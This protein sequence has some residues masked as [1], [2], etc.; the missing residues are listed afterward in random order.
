MDKEQHVNKTLRRINKDGK[1]PVVVIYKPGIVR[2]GFLV[3]NLEINFIEAG[4]NAFSLTFY[5]DTVALKSE[6]EKYNQFDTD[7][8]SGFLEN[9]EIYDRIIGAINLLVDSSTKR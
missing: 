9:T 4:I 7:D 2:D 5:E 6:F 3:R 1:T 8:L